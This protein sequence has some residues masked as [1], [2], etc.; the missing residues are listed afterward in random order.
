MTRSLFTGQLVRL[1]AIDADADAAFFAQSDR[2]SDYMRF[3]DSGPNRLF[4]LKQIK[5][6]LAREMS[7]AADVNVLFGMR[8]LADDRLIGF[9]GLDGIRWLHGD[10][11]IAIGIA[12][13]AYRGQGYGT[14]ALRVALR[15]AFT[16]LNLHRVSLDVFDYNRRAL[17]TYE[18]IGF[19]VEGRMRQALRRDGR[20]HDLIF[21]GI[22]R[23]EWQ[24]ANES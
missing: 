7:E 4:T 18:K 13:A 5:A 9:V 11:F 23:A 22:L 15:Y 14:D 6:E 8:T 19:V 16:E 21:M 1:A 10:T 24:K 17:H 12:E 2:D 3:L 20:Y